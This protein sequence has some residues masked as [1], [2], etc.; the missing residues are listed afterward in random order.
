MSV[1]CSSLR[2]NGTFSSFAA[3]T[4][5]QRYS[6]HQRLSFA[7]VL[8]YSPVC[9]ARTLFA[10]LFPVS[11]SF[12]LIGALTID[13]SL[14]SRGAHFTFGSHQSHGTLETHGFALFS[15]GTT[16]IAT[17]RSFGAVRSL[18]TTHS[19]NAVPSGETVRSLV[20]VLSPFPT[21]TLFSVL[22]PRHRLAHCQRYT[23]CI[24]AH[25]LD[26]VPSPC[27][28]RSPH[29]GSLTQ[30]GCA[31]HRRYTSQRTARTFCDG[32]YQ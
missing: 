1:G 24:S 22:T 17:A 15:F 18:F 8:R 13:D 31:L 25:S 20:T 28:D 9:T 30:I 3:R 4:T 14:V 21:H 7:P 11:G 6:H 2:I 5:S 26:S 32:S 27:T 10:V 23:H 12:F 16:P 19:S 29:N